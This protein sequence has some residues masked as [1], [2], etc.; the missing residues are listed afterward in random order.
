L[1]EPVAPLPAPSASSAMLSPVPD[2]YAYKQPFSFPPCGIADALNLTFATL[3]AYYSPS[4]TAPLQWAVIEPVLQC[5][6]GEVGLEL[7]FF[8]NNGITEEQW[9]ELASHALVYAQ[10]DQ[11]PQYISA[12][13]GG[14][15]FPGVAQCAIDPQLVPVA[16]RVGRQ[17][18]LGLPPLA[19]MHGRHLFIA[20]WF[21]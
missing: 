17:Q 16:V 5:L 2:D 11:V 4:S 10:T 1:N 18:S 12:K 20:S 13:V 15:G 9:Y 8:K 6:E 19:N 3:F 14:N 7:A 21:A